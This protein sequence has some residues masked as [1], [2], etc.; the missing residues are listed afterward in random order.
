MWRSIKRHHFFYRRKGFYKFLSGISVKFAAFFALVLLGL[1][2]FEY[3]TPGMVHYFT[4]YTSKLSNGLIVGFFFAS[5]FFLGLVPPDLFIVWAKKF[6]SPYAVVTLLAVLSYSAGLLAYFFGVRLGGMNRINEYIHKRYGQH[7][8]MLRSW[9]G[10]LI[11]VAALLPLPFSIMCMGAGILRY[12]FRML[13]LLG[14]FRIARFFLYAGV[15]YQ[16]V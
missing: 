9:G 7:F 12:S 8:N 6:S 11:I 3:A 16:V 4:L 10:F 13:M 15:L 2:I 1:G 14:V 5:E